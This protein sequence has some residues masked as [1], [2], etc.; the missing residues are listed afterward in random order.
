MSDVLRIGS[1]KSSLAK[2]QTCLVQDSLRKLYPELEL[3]LL[4]KEASG[5]QDLTTPLWKMGSKGVFTQ[6]LTKELVDGN[7]D[8]VI[9]SFKDLDLDG[10]KDTEVFMVLPRA[11]QRDV[12]LWKKSA[13]EN[14]PA[15]LKIHSSSPRREYN[16][17][18]FLP[19]ALPSRLQGRPISFHPVRGNVQTRIRKWKEDPSVSGLVVA[20]AALDRLLAQDF[21][22][23]STPEYEEVRNGIAE[24]I[25]SELFMVLPLS[26]NPNAPAQ[27]AL[28]AEIR[29]GDEKTK[30]LLLPLSNA[31]EEAAVAEERKILSQF[32]GGCHQKIG[33]S[34][35][36]GGPAD[37]LFVRGKTDSGLTLDAFE[38][39]KGEPLPL[40]SS[41]DAVFPKPRQ[42]FRMKRFPLQS[43]IPSEKFWFVSRADSLP[44][45]WKLPGPDTIMIVAGAKT[46]EK[47]ASRDVWVNGSTDGLGEEDASK[48]VSILGG[49]PEFIKLTHEES[50][51]IEGVWKRFVTYKVDFDSEQPDLSEYSHFFWMSASQ[52]DRAYKKDP[53]LAGKIHSCGTGA[54]YKYIKKILGSEAKVFA[55]PNYESWAK[56]CRG[57]IPDFLLERGIL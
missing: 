16:L 39:W 32:G 13:F 3:Q 7:V 19:T 28:A 9:H 31:R 33:V 23:A 18:A 25:R 30:K 43:S 54:T 37:F 56:A 6:D 20:K 5:D 40:P 27:G 14:P 11:D 29:K 53:N 1:R 52:F 45:E 22:F 26:K 21:S 2:L 24:T 35:I 57:E 15:E 50:D 48:I 10:R 34:V 51:I 49:S 55:F 12:L 36:L 38:R 8:V 41:F 17:S 44:E 4:F 47:L 46:W 42:G